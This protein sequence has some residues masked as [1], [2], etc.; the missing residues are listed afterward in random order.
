MLDTRHWKANLQRRNEDNGGASPHAELVVEDEGER[1]HT[2]GA[3]TDDNIDSLIHL[4][5]L[6][7]V[8]WLR[9]WL[10]HLILVLM[11]LMQQEE[12]VQS[13]IRPQKQF[14]HMIQSGFA[15]RKHVFA[16]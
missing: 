7:E 16:Q 4:L 12:K 11:L 2:L 5:L 10:L 6:L 1:S 3:R 13:L 9:L 14:G 15:I 8:L